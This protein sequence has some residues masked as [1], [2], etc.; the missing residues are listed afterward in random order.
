MRIL[1][2][3]ARAANYT[4]S[5]FVTRQGHPPSRCPLSDLVG[6]VSGRTTPVTPGATPY[7][8]AA[9]R[10]LLSAVRRPPSATADLASDSRAI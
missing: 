1:S 2:L 10:R 9:V 7:H 6:P 3:F 5:A 8:E 4:H